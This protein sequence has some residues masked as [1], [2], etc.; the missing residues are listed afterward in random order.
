MDSETP[1]KINKMIAGA[2]KIAVVLPQYL[3]LDVLCAGL[4]LHQKFTSIDG[5]Q[6][7]LFSSAK[8]IPLVEFN[9]KLP[10]IHSSFGSG[11]ELTI[12]VSGENVKPKQLRYE[13]IQDDLFI[14]VAPENSTTPEV[15][16]TTG[17]HSQFTIADV[18]VVPP[19]TTFDLLIIIGAVNLETLGTLYEKNPEVF[20]STAKIAINN[21]IEQEYFATATWVESDIPSLSQQLGEW[22]L[23]TPQVS[24]NGTHLFLSDDFITTN[25][26]AGIIS[27]TQSFSDPKTTPNTLALAAKLVASGA[28]RQDI[29]KYLFKTKPFNLLQLW[30]RA[31][32]R[33]KTFQNET[34]L[35]TQIT[36]QDFTKTNT[37]SELLSDVISEI[38]NMANNY[39]LIILAAEVVNGVELLFAGPPHVKI[40][41]LAKGIDPTF[42][43]QSEPL[44][45]NYQYIK[46]NLPDFKLEDLDQVVSTL[47][48]TGI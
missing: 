44:L 40:K 17:N 35:Y 33:I 34:I 28:R 1:I 13:K 11:N 10:V 42:A 20:Y 36:A 22:F 45:G 12:K 14:Y 4:S 24:N 46:L 5:K 38:I 47:S 15:S 43:G 41:Q 30:G 3:N 26:L 9:H 18:E 2:T 21:K 19:L 7:S 37:T 32:A 48:A 29:I 31:L 8:T 16:V 27:A 6:V 25:L 39:K 23:Q